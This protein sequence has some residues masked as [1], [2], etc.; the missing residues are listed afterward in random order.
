[1]PLH[2]PWAVLQCHWSD[3]DSVPHEREFYEDL[4]TA[5]G[6]GSLN[7]TDYFADCA[8]GS[9]DLSGTQIFGPYDLGYAKS[10]Y[11]GNAAPGDGQLDRGAMMAR[12]KAVAAADGVAIEAFYGVVVC[13][14]DLTDLF[15][16][17][18][19]GAC[20]DQGSLRPAVLG[21]E[22]GHV[23]GLSH[24][25]RDGST[26][27]YQDPWDTMSTWSACYIAANDRWTEVGPGLNAC[28]MRGRGWL[29]ETRVWRSHYENFV[30]EIELRP[31]HRRDLPGLLAAE[32]PDPSA[33]GGSVL[34]ELR[35]QERWDA[36]IPE[37]TVLVH[38]F[39][40][41]TSYLMSDTAGG[42]NLV[43]GEA[44]QYG[45]DRIPVGALQWGA[46]GRVEVLSISPATHTARIRLTH[47]PAGRAHVPQQGGGIPFG[48][49]EVDGGGAL[50]FLN[51]KVIRIPPR[52]PLLG[53]LEQLSV[54][55]LADAVGD[56][57]ARDL[58]RSS[59]LQEITAWAQS[60]L[61]EIHELATPPP[62][63]KQVG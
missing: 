46:Y 56:T 6:A 35:V 2:T 21:Q 32:L 11:V 38:R 62:P 19:I 42:A 24:S 54:H 22:M 37:A 13:F 20:C 27:D 3:D 61:E 10:A 12:A 43:E 7:M 45:T 44:F 31:L 55:Q 23:Y 5:S 47:R 29:D 25:R 57:A 14:N 48:G 53:I 41:N 50:I 30:E 39:D 49:I 9:L 4:F 17:V 33:S 26:A 28:N 59:A 1:M 40:D 18:G 36:A 8:H 51:G 34:V 60:G 52:S 15:G 16:G 63:V 58:V